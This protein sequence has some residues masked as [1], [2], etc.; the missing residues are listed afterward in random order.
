[1]TKDSQREKTRNVESGRST[2]RTRVRGVTPCSKNS[3]QDPSLG[4]FRISVPR[5]ATGGRSQAWG[6]MPPAP[7]KSSR[8]VGPAMEERLVGETFSGQWES[9][10]ATKTPMN[11]PLKV[12]TPPPH[13][14][15][16]RSSSAQARNAVLPSPISHLD[17]WTVQQALDALNWLL[18]GIA[19]LVVAGTLL[20]TEI[21]S[22]RSLWTRLALEFDLTKE[23]TAAT[24]FES[25]LFLAVG[26]S[27]AVLGWARQRPSTMTPAIAGAY[28]AAALLAAFLAMDEVIVIHEMLGTRLTQTTG[29]GEQIPS[30]GGG[31]S[32]LLLYGP[33]LIL[34]VAVFHYAVRRLLAP[35]SASARRA[36][37]QRLATLA[38]LVP[39]FLGLEWLG[40]HLWSTKSQIDLVPA[41]E[42]TLE[43]CILFLVLSVNLRLIR[44][45]RL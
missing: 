37:H 40:G 45:Y 5:G 38:V 25:V 43:L 8:S 2:L 29:I 6:R 19:T 24:W 42:E 23:G 3:R 9:I 26:V 1:M 4:E 16:R 14:S 22:S 15:R 39:L 41:I 27:C 35:F 7:R 44:H 34:V 12:A 11:S 13:R 33:V 30:L 32:W 18:M 28:R 31:Y 17:P 21:D 20:G 10:P 36:I